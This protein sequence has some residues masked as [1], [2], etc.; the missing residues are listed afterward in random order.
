MK[1]KIFLFHRVTSE[2]DPLW[3]PMDPI[4]FKRVVARIHNNYSVL[5][6]NELL[7]NKKPTTNKIACAIVFDD[8]YRDFLDFALPVLNQYKL[9]CCMCVVTDCVNAQLPPWTYQLDDIF[10]RTQKKG[11][12]IEIEWLPLNFKNRIWHNDDQRLRYARELKIMMKG[13]DDKRRLELFNAVKSYFDDVEMKKGLMMN[14]NELIEIHKMGIEIASHTVSHPMLANIA[15]EKE[16]YF[17]LSES[18]DLI[19]ENLGEA[20]VTISYPAGSYDERVKK[21]AAEVGYLR[22]LA[23][24]Q[25][26]Y[27]SHAN[28]IFEVPRIELYNEPMWK[29]N[30]REKEIIQKLKRFK[31]VFNA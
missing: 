13:I 20:P 29:T 25:S 3:D 14:W 19:K 15:N 22:G 2:R 28:D 21:I 7:D 27:N 26:A 23:V 4:H 5:S 18:Y 24:N 12:K 8:G 6:L 17:Q 9:P 10:V 16:I 1:A 30:L 31:K 11:I